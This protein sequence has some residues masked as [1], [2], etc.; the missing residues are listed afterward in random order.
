MPNQF[1]T[2]TIGRGGWCPG[3]DVP[4]FVADVSAQASAGTEVTLTYK[5][6]LDFEEWQEGDA[7]F[8]GS[9]WM[10]SYLVTYE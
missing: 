1:G 4:P 9:I 5:G 10:S 3:K 7:G 2:W 8:G 6:Y